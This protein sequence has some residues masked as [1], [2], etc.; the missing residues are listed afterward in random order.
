MTFD[1][2]ELEQP[3]RTRRTAAR[4][5]SPRHVVA[6]ASTNGERREPLFVSDGTARILELSDGTR[7]ALE[8]AAAAGSGNGHPAGP[9][10]LEQIEELFRSGLLMLQDARP[11][12]DRISAPPP[13]RSDDSVSPSPANARPPAGAGSAAAT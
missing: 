12:P 3:A 6:F 13:S 5:P 4:Q 1:V 9:H 10:G 8:I 7:T 11:Q 2:S